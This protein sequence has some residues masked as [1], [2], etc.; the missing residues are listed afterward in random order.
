MAAPATFSTTTG[1]PFQRLCRFS[2]TMRAS[3]SVVEPGAEGTTIL[4]VRDGNAS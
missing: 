4:T 1:L 3:E 2:A